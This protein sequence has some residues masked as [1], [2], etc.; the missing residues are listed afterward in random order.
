M[1]STSSDEIGSYYPLIAESAR[2]SPDFSW[3]EVDINPH[4]RFHDGAPITAE[5][6]A[7]T[8]NKF[9]TEGV[10]QFRLFYK[11]VKVNAISRLTVRFEFPEPNKDKMLGLLGFPVMPKHF[12]KDHKL[13]DPL[14]TPQ[15]P[16]ALTASANTKWANMSLMNG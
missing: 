5:D 7:F 13:S 1:F 3:I 8:F 11:G 12:W 2:Y 16:V 10:P 4:A 9:M 15:S 6:V 14:S